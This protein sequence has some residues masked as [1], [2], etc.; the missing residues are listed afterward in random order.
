MAVPGCQLDYIWNELQ[1][2]IRGL[3]CGPDLEVRR[4]KYLTW[5]LV[6]KSWGIVAMKSLGPDKVVN[7]FNPRR[8]RQGDLWV[9]SQPGT[10]QVPI[11]AWWYTPLIWATPSSGDLHK[12]IGR[13]KIH[14]SLS[15]C[16][17]L[18]AHLLQYTSAE[19][20]LKLALLDWAT[21]RYLD[22]PFKADHC[23]E[24][25]YRL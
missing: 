10:L 3:T 21:I 11:Q 8:L 22:F 14:S 23:W 20:Q 9:Q 5:I 13:R 18:P 4:H 24:L 15:A 16:T 7:T 25:D 2:G 19:D 17:Y 1:F 12:N 6:W